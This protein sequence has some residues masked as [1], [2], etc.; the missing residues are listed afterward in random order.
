MS[1]Q[2]IVVVPAKANSSRVPR[3]NFRPFY[4]GKS[5]VDITLDI[6]SSSDTNCE[7]ILSTDNTDYNCQHNSVCVLPRSSSLS[8]F[9]TPILAVLK[10]ILSRFDPREVLNIVLVQ[11]TS[12]FRTTDDFDS[13]LS[14]S[15]DIHLEDENSRSSTSVFSTY[16]VEDAHPARM[17]FSVNSLL[18]PVLS[19]QADLQ[20]QDLTDCYHRNGCF[21]SF[22][23]I[24]LLSNHLYSPTVRN[25][26]MPYISSLNIDT[27]IDFN[28]AQLA[29][30]LFLDNSIFTLP[31]VD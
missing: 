22:S 27:P 26:N 9:E 17:Y 5:L 7:L 18:T 21:Y 11:P 25:Y 2:T 16:R 23:P 24:S 1:K 3:K 30:P 12:P 31:F 28:I 14:F 4:N 15:R 10:H 6:I 29:F 20:C 13:F 19:H 8:L